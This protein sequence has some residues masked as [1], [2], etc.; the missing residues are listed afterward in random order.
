[1]STALAR[2]DTS[3]VNVLASSNPRGRGKI[4]MD[5]SAWCWTKHVAEYIIRIYVCM[6]YTIMH[7]NKK[8]E[9]KCY[10]SRSATSA[11]SSR[12]L[13]FSIAVGLPEENINYPQPSQCTAPIPD[14]SLRPTM[15]QAWSWSSWNWLE[16][17][18]LCTPKA[19][20]KKFMI[21]YS[22]GSCFFLNMYSTSPDDPDAMP[23]ACPLIPLWFHGAGETPGIDQASFG[24]VIL[25]V[26]CHVMIY[27]VC[28]KKHQPNLVFQPCQ[29][30]SIQPFLFGWNHWPFHFEAQGFRFWNSSTARTMGKKTCV[31]WSGCELSQLGTRATVPG[32]F[33]ATR[34]GRGGSRAMLSDLFGGL[35]L[36]RTWN[37][38]DCYVYFDITL[39]II[40]T[41]DHIYIYIHIMYI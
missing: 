31:G 32:D 4:S 30:K 2:L 18:K 35:G 7:W 34:G 20:L 8:P 16:L 10:Q 37:L 38:H 39:E 23:W 11:T 26:T 1:M 41:N 9:I 40:Y 33:S 6:Q 25:A 3:A 19:S 36:R 15:R 29:W 17:T 24:R 28:G 22:N 21:H 5:L 14:A 27:D 13:L 12:N